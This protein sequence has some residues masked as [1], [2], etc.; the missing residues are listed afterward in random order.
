MWGRA[1]LPVRSSADRPAAPQAA[2]QSHPNPDPKGRHNAAQ[3]LPRA[4]SK[5]RKPW[6]E[7]RREEPGPGGAKDE[8]GS[9][10]DTPATPLQKRPSPTTDSP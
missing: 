7:L 5:G 2:K 9:R 8:F 1:L 4:T 6:E 3:S 10:K